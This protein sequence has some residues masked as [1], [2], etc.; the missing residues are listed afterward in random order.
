M[1]SEL[2]TL[3]R[4]LDLSVNCVFFEKSMS[5]SI[6][7]NL[8]TR[9]ATS[10]RIETLIKELKEKGPLVALAQIGPKSYADTP[11]KLLNKMC[12][13]DI[14]GWRYGAK[15]HAFSANSCVMVLGAKKLEDREYV[16]FTMSDDITLDQKTSKRVHRPSYTDTKVY[17]TSHTTFRIYLFELYQPASPSQE[18]SVFVIS[19]H[20][21][22][23]P[24]LSP[25][26]QKYAER[27]SSISPLESIL[28]MGEEERK[29]KEIG[30]EIFNQFKAE[31]DGKS[32]EGKAA[33]QRIC[34]AV[35][36]MTTD[37][38]LRKQYIERAWDGIG[39]DNWRWMA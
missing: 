25:S 28:D 38:A 39:D 27:L 11:F 2:S 16:Y 10:Q 6:D 21:E 18:K 8:V 17:V 4:A 13:Q 15:R 19:S 1:I 20:P 24:E 14:Y 34:N 7:E 32:S 37:G 23:S 31:N 9:Y 30:Q 5:L 29:C 12:H 36:F 26:E 35:A 33:V 3:P 22:I